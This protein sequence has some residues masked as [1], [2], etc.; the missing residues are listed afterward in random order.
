[1][2]NGK[3][4]GGIILPSASEICFFTEVEGFTVK[5]T[6]FVPTMLSAILTLIVI[7]AII[8]LIFSR[9][10]EEGEGLLRG[11]KTGAKIG[12]G[13]LAF[14]IIILVLAMSLFFAIAF[15]Q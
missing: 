15:A 3:M 6:K 10:G 2:K 9:R 11:A 8:G 13:C 12:C 5:Y 7:G 4:V 14:V 1:M